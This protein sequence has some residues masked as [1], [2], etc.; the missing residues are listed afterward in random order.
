MKAKKSVFGTSIK[1]KTIKV[2]G[3]DA[4]RTNLAV[5]KPLKPLYGK[6]P[7]VKKPHK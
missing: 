3:L 1:R 7:T 5:P 6:M 4:R 2:K